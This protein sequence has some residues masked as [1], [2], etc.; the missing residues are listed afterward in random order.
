MFL[1]GVIST[2]IGSVLQGFWQWGLIVL[3]ML[4]AGAGIS[5]AF[6]RVEGNSSRWRDY[7]VLSAAIEDALREL[8]TEDDRPITQRWQ[9]FCDEWEAIGKLEQEL[10]A[11]RVSESQSAASSEVKAAHD[12]LQQIRRDYRD[13]KPAVVGDY[14][15][16]SNVDRIVLPKAVTAPEYIEGTNIT[17]AEYVQRSMGGFAEIV[18]TEI[19]ESEIEPETSSL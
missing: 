15:R 12:N 13:S 8:L 2:A 17:P 1:G 16:R 9:R 7:A 18:Q 5:T 10:F 11:R 4:Q 3:A 14:D 6:D 19:D